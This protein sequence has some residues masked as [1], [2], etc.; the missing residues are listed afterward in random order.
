MKATFVFVYQPQKS[1][2]HSRFI[3]FTQQIYSGELL[4][5]TVTYHKL[6]V[7]NFSIH[8]HKIPGTRLR[9]PDEPPTHTVLPALENRLGCWT[10]EF[11]RKKGEKQPDFVLLPLLNL[12]VLDRDAA[13]FSRE[14]TLVGS[15]E[16]WR[17][18]RI[19]KTFP[20]PPVNLR[21][22]AVRQ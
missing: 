9:E 11:K 2:E 12:A 1:S 8:P 21:H 6:L 4:R 14:R 20:L 7:T 17:P 19:W 16:G 13:V 10:S 22:A 15:A 3:T 18:R 5:P